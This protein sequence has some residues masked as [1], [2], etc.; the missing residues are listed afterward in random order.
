MGECG[1]GRET[2]GGEP[3]QFLGW[4]W[5][6]VQGE[7]LRKG[8]VIVREVDIIMVCVC[9]C[10]CACACACACVQAK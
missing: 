9:V 7:G 8:D 2:W 3:E 10:T 5:V 4:C 6:A 1:G